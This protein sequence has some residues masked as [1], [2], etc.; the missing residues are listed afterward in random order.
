MLNEKLLLK[1]HQELSGNK[2]VGIDKVTKEEYSQNLRENIQSLVKRLK[3]KSYK[4]LPVKRVYIPK[5]N[6]KKRP[7]GIAAY[8]DKIVQLGLKKILEAVY[9]PKFK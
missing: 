3:N 5:A 6:G 4:P 7:L 9:E 1:C 2:A 8:E